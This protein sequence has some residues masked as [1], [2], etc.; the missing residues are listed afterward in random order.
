MLMESRGDKFV[1]VEV[2]K[3]VFLCMTTLLYNFPS[4][5]VLRSRLNVATIY[6]SEHFTE[7]M[8]P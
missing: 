1:F 3:V 4:C 5:V 7:H 8:E 6:T 2:S